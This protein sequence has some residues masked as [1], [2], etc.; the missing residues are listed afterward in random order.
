MRAWAAW[1][2]V[3][4]C[5]TFFSVFLFW[6][7]IELLGFV[8]PLFNFFSSFLRFLFC[9]FLHGFVFFSAPIKPSKSLQQIKFAS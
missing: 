2:R 1:T 3:C 8:L 6:V 5:V 4:L 7:N 9:F